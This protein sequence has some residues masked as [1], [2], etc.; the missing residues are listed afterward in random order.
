MVEGVHFFADTDPELL[1]HKILAVNLSDMAAM[2]AEPKWA[3]LALTLPNMDEQ[4][5]KK[6]STTL[7]T[8]AA[9]YNVQIIGGDTTQGPLNLCINIM[10]LLPK[11]QAL[12]RAGAN[13]GDD[14]YVSNVIGDAA[15]ALSCINGDVLSNDSNLEQLRKA[16]DTP[17]PQVALG[18]ELLSIASAC[19]DISDGLIAD[20]GH[21]ARQSQ[22]SF[23]I[24]IGLIPL[25]PQYQDYI[26]E[27]GTVDLALSGGDDYQLAFTASQRHADAIQELSQVLN[28]AITKIGK[29]VETNNSAVS[30]FS[31][32]KPTVLN[33]QFGYEHFNG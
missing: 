24:D 11:G 33:K 22:V 15:L 28:I 1:A 12:T 9:N 29:V 30:L 2:G 26:R 27:G 23:E 20:L 3:T 10:G 5:L 32:G 6:F 25:S 8:V 7:S 4:W 13:L 16:L 14:L 19:L 17:V 18:R 31:D 21:I